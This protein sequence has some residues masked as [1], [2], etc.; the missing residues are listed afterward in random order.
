MR[1]AALREACARLTGNEEL[2][3]SL[4][5]QDHQDLPW[6][7]GAAWTEAETLA[8]AFLLTGNCHFPEL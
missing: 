2:G 7:A 5:P 4:M 1:A 6:R 8:A 3:L